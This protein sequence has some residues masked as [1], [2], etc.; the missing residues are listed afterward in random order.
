MA[1]TANS[2]LKV[3]P[4]VYNAG[5]GDTTTS[6]SRTFN[7]RIE[8][9]TTVEVYYNGQLIESEDFDAT[10]KFYYTI[11]NSTTN[12]ISTALVNGH[13]YRIATAGTANWA[14]AGATSNAIG[15]LFT[16]SGTASGTGTAEDLTIATTFTFSIIPNP[17]YAAPG[18]ATGTSTVAISAS[19]NF[20]LSYYHV[21]YSVA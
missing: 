20:T 9:S 15:T 10:S 17:A 6:I 5:L 7:D 16:A 21:L 4:V 8:D 3:N 18:Y 1:L 14:P 13:N 12:T 19:D 2:F 11:G